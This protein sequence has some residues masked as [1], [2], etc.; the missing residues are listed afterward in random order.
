MVGNYGSLGAPVAA[1]A[2]CCRFPGQIL[3][4]TIIAFGFLRIGETS[5][6]WLSPSSPNILVEMSDIK[7]NIS[8]F[9]SFVIK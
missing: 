4:S 5:Q 3:K 8:L 7:K 2:I 6:M 1:I 9:H